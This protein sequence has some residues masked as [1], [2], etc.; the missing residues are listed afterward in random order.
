MT[1]RHGPLHIA[2]ALVRRRRYKPAFPWTMSVRRDGTSSSEA[3]AQPGLGELV[4]RGNAAVGHS[5]RLRATARS[6]SEGGK[7]VDALQA[8][9]ESHPG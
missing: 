5:D 4:E 8:I 3:F 7:I 9:A 2:V 6:V 1:R